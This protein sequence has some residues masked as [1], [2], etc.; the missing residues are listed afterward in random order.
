MT[1]SDEKLKA[2][3]ARYD[4]ELLARLLGATEETEQALDAAGVRSK[5]EEPEAPEAPEA[6]AGDEPEALEDD[7]DGLSLSAEDM[8]AVAEIVTKAVDAVVG[9]KLQ[10]LLDAITAAAPLR[11][12]AQAEAAAKIGALTDLVVAVDTRLQTGRAHHSLDE[13]AGT[14]A[15][16]R[17]DLLLRKRSTTVA[18][19]QPVRGRSKIA[20]R[21]DERAVQIEDD[22]AWRETHGIQN[23][24]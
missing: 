18:G 4:S 10:P 24:E 12:K 17:S 14:L 21:I 15:D 1:I 9:A 3:Q 20:T 2:L 16:H 19:D 6:P 8:A 11:E 23:A 7:D 13:D 22:E 5:A